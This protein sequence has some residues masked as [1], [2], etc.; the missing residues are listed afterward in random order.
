MATWFEQKFS[1][2]KFLIYIWLSKSADVKNLG[3]WMLIFLDGITVDNSD[4][5][6]SNA[7]NDIYARMIKFHFLCRNPFK[8]WYRVEIYDIKQ[9]FNGKISHLRILIEYLKNVKLSLGQPVTIENQIDSCWPSA[10]Q[11]GPLKSNWSK[12]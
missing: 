9:K 5:I 2:F 10:Q 12:N 1:K 8:I 6:F 3:L 4:L 7:F 11:H